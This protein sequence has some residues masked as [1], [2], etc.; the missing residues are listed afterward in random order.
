MRRRWLA[1][2]AALMF[3]PAAGAAAQTAHEALKVL[4]AAHE[5]VRGELHGIGTDLEAAAGRLAETGLEGDG[6]RR[7]LL[8]I[9]EGRPW[10]VDR[11]T[12]SPGGV[13][14][15]VEP[16]FYRKYE[17]MS[18]AGQPHAARVRETGQ[19]VMSQVFRSVEGLDAAAVAHPV[20]S[21]AGGFAGAVSF[22]FRPSEMLATVIEP[23]AKGTAVEV[24]VMQPDGRVLYHT[25]R[26]MIGRN[27]VASPA[28]AHDP[29]L[30]SLAGLVARERIGSAVYESTDDLTGRP[31]EKQAHWLTAGLHGAEWRIVAAAASPAG[32]SGRIEA[33]LREEA[34]ALIRTQVQMAVSMLQA[35]YEKYQ[36]GQISLDRAKAFS[37]D[38][39]RG[40]R[41]GDGGDG[42]FW[43][44]T[45]DGV[46]V[47]LPGR[48]DAEGKNR[49][50]D[51]IEDQYYVREIIAR[52]R[53]PGG[54]YT[55]YHFPKGDG[56]TPLR[57]RAYSL[58]FRPFGWVVGTA[59]HVDDLERRAAARMKGDG[60]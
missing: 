53:Q 5:E 27:L 36:L 30:P 6:A 20:R 60:K 47:V 58:L 57:A 50:D 34:D 37:A 7:I 15:A 31:A 56:R 51:V 44:D 18:I 49:F 28:P 22:L 16:E 40:L 52:G 13:L 21:G 9:R 24:W 17:G 39:L 32:A 10:A 41:Y 12:V 8:G 29:R 55:D 4:L 59:Y 25:Q 46:N 43:A 19:P 11:A 35:V 23:V 33:I 2:L 14:L 1:A 45:T 54:G 38:L 48:D 42:C 3:L 26:G